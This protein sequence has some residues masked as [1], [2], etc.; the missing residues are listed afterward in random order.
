MVG[1]FSSKALRFNS[2]KFNDRTIGL[3][4]CT[5]IVV[6][7]KCGLWIFHLWEI[8][9]FS[10]VQIDP[11]TNFK[12]RNSETAVTNSEFHS[13]VLNFLR[14]EGPSDTETFMVSKMRSS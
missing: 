13:R 12:I 10:N 14:S 3:R 11:A 9:E 6:V 1:V 2:F 7:S 4:G 8:P 5:A